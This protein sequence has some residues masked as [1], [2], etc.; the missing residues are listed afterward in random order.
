MNTAADSGH[1]R[2]CIWWHQA[3]L[4]VIYDAL[5][6]KPGVLSATFQ[7]EYSTYDERPATPNAPEQDT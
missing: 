4:P 3:M 6:Q 1:R 5:K 7:I 2:L